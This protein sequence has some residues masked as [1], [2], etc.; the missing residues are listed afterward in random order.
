MKIAMIGWEY[1]PFKTGGLGTHCYGLTRSLADKNIQVDFYMPKTKHKT[2]SDKHNLVIR[3]IGETDI[4]PYDRPE[5]KELAGQFFES[6]YRYNDLIVEKV[7]GDYDLIHCHD[8]LTMKAGIALKTKLG[9][10]LVLSVHSTEYDRSGWLNPN[11][12]FINIEKEGMEKADQI[13]AVS[14]FTKRVI[15]DKYWINP[16]K[17]IV[18]HNAVYPIPEGQKQEIVLFL[19]RLTIQ[20]GAE[21]FLKAARKVLDYESDTR[22][23]IAGTG[24]MLPK[25]IDQAVGMG[26]SNRV[27]SKCLPLS[28]SS[29]LTVFEAIILS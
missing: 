16:N 22:F 13:I 27:I 23:V 4:F 6:V 26:I 11:E 25:L 24:D 20:K 2:V 5:D 3:E 12:W 18:V 14:H 21:F 8:W 19:G 15:I 7:K 10:P 29:I 1:P 28:A 17:I 9:I